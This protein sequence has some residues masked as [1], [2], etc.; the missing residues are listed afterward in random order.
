M[1]KRIFDLWSSRA[2]AERAAATVLAFVVGALLCFWFI[3]TA[4]Q[5]RNRLKQRVA[6]LKSQSD[7]MD[8][9]ISEFSRLKVASANPSTLAPKNLRDAVQGII[10]SSGLSTSLVKIDAP[11][12][13]T[14]QVSFSAL[15]FSDWLA[16]VRNLQAQ[17][18]RIE[19]CRIEALTT[20]GRISITAT[21][22]SA[23]T[24]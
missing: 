18:I 3:H 22:S 20:A 12:A 23:R 19:T 4:E 17:K 1:K 8:Q 7:T 2:P 5:E 21:L 9:Q 10:D 13:G 11:D 24:R 15:S 6:V 14:A 16:F